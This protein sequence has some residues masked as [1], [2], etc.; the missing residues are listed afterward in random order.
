MDLKHALKSLER[1]EDFK[2]VCEHLMTETQAFSSTFDRD[3]I[4]MAAK[5]AKQELG[6]DFGIN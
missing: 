4:L 2:K 1:N 3:P 5:S 6:L